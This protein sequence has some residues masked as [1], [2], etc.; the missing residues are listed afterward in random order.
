[1]KLYEIVIKPMSGFRTPLKGDTLF[2]HFCWQ[3][4]YDSTLLNGGLDKWIE[5]YQSRPFVVFSSA[6]P[7]F[8]HEGEFYYALKRPDLPLPYLFPYSGE[9]KK[10]ALEKLK[11]NKK[12]KWMKVKEDLSIAPGAENF[13]ND[14]ELVCM[15]QKQT[16]EETKIAMKKNASLDFIVER[17]S[18]HNIINRLT[19]TTGEGMFAP[20]SESSSFYY[21]ETEL[22][23]FV[24]IDEDATDIERVISGIERTGAIG[25]GRDASTGSGK[26]EMGESEEKPLPSVE[27]ANACYVLGPVV[28]EK[29]IYIDMYF[30]PFI[31]F[32]K[33]GDI[34]ARSSTPF[35]NPVIM[36]NEGA[37]FVGG[38]AG[39]FKKPY[40]GMAA[41]NTSKIKDHNVVHQGYAPY[42]PFRLE[43][44]K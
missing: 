29:N 39:I 28:P 11:E 8:C 2:G 20:Y 18:H 21:P 31:R 13:M 35:K 40:I 25:F 30:S 34:L 38:D 37:V 6:W 14:A 32:G 22:A 15:A 36:A 16:T 27:T 26:F 43:M 42:L 7:K 10:A 1:M 3:A 44:K 5:V 19:D 12:K 33:H 17:D 23:I 4:A 24:L 9:N 41:L